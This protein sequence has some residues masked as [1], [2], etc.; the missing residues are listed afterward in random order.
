MR[1]N[2]SRVLE[3][4]RPAALDEV[5]LIVAI[6]RGSLRRMV[7]NAEISYS[8][9]LEGDASLLSQF[10]IAYQNSAY[11]IVQECQ[12]VDGAVFRDGPA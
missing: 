7:E 2:I 11:R 9:T 5:G 10:D 8:M 4:L 1:N 3:A 12:F 6:D